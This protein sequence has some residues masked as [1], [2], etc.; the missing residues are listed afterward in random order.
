MGGGD[1]PGPLMFFPGPRS[2]KVA[3]AADL[4][5]DL[6]CHCAGV[7]PAQIWVAHTVGTVGVLCTPGGGRGWWGGGGGEIFEKFEC[8]FH[9]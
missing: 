7:F 2:P 4:P 5:E 9:D 6:Q 3:L 1:H 8:I